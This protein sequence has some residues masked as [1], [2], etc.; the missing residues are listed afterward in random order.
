MK[1]II[2]P[3]DFSETA[4]N[5]ARYAIGLAGQTGATRV[6]LYHAYELIVPIPDLPTAVPMVNMEDLR[7]SSLEGLR[8]MQTE[9]A[10]MVPSGVRLDMRA[11]NHLLAANID[12]VCREELADIIVMGI[13][14]GSQLE[15]ILVGSNTV[16][17]VKSS[18]YPVIVV[19][20]K[21]AFRPI[22]K[23]VFACDLRKVAKTT[24]R[25]PLLKI[26]DEF[27]PELH[28][29]NIQKEGKENIHPEENQELDNMLHNYNPQYHFIDRPNIA[30]AITGFA[31]E[32]Y[33]DLLLIIPKKHGIFDSIFKRGHTSRIAFQT[34]VPLLSIHE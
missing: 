9:L 18:A 30:D 27:K 12:Q 34:N 32:Q 28:V 17:V 4:Y 16:D 11:D 1:T 19:P 31:E 33:A 24:R 2:V 29:V 13:T 6:I 14:G 10:P 3:T 22:R 7:E 15:E 23:I 5:A 26:L 20:T 21:A 25:E 8:R